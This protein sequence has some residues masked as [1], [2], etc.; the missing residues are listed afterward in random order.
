VKLPQTITAGTEDGTP[1]RNETLFKLGCSLRGKGMGEDEILAALT[2][3]NRRCEPP[4]GT[5]E[6][7][8]I[9][10]S[11]ASYPAAELGGHARSPSAEAAADFAAELEATEHS[12]PRL[13][14]SPKE[15]MKVARELAPRWTH[16]G[17]PT[18][19]HWRGGWWRWQRSHWVELEHRSV[20]AELYA[21]TEHADYLVKG[22]DGE[23]EPVPWAPNR[24]KIAD[25]SE[26]LAAITW[27]DESIA[28]PCWLE[29]EHINR[30]TGTTVSCANG[31]LDLELRELLE[32]TNLFFNQ[33]AVPFDYDAGA[34]EPARW[35]AFLRELWGDDEA[36]I[37]ALAEWFGYVISGHLD[38]HKIL[39]LVGPPR[40]GKGAIARVLGALV[41]RDNVAGPTLNSLGANFGLQPLIG[42]SLAVVA[43]ARL[44]GRAASTVV[45]RLLSVSG[46]DTLTVDR[47][48]RDPWTG[49]LPSRFFVISN[50]LP[51]L[52]DAS[53]AIASRFV[54]L[55]LSRSWL[56]KEDTELEPRLHGELPGI[57]NW[58]LDGLERLERQGRFTVP[59]STSEA[60]VALQDLA[61]PVG[62][63]VRERCL[64]G[65]EHAVP[66]EDLW[67]AWSAWATD[68]NAPRST[69][70]VFGRDLRAAHLGIR[71]TQPGSGDNPPRFYAGIGLR[72][73]P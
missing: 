28:D 71:V 26:A 68:N 1:G 4:L 51:R 19:R 56:G 9:A 29:G 52:G 11:A 23:P 3:A 21:L 5:G 25:L 39:L 64:L 42:K 32:H 49:K 24:H 43:D 16:Q 31:L 50:E 45:E 47:K 2:A 36:A 20:R 72:R 73:I 14:Q 69:K 46:E 65:A 70:Q 17:T 12:E 38:L 33:T 55:V 53:A 30:A 22:K 61:S 18:L 62:A 7:E 34:P 41:G 63:F 35:L 60:F 10:A 57:L 59:A 44:D 6:L 54:T 13:L 15:P 27:L 58:A 66:V 67:T 37:A 48:Y 40:A 8:A